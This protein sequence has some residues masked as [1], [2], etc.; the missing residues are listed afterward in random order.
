MSTPPPIVGG[1][2]TLYVRDFDAAVRFYTET[3]GL[4]LR[5]RAGDD[6]AE[7]V[8]GRDLVIGLHPAR[9]GRGRPGTAG[10]VQ[11]GLVV[12]GPL[13]EVL[14]ALERRGVT[15]DGPVIRSAADGFAWAGIKDM[16][17]NALYLWEKPPEPARAS[18]RGTKA[19]A[20]RAGKPRRRA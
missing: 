10:A 19:A 1:N 3:L 8:A 6:W 11:I 7:V 9:P 4:P 5:M 12:T 17:G 18:R 20:R 2:A 15:V 14:A 13:E 16:D